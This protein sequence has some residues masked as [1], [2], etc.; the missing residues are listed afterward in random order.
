[1]CCTLTVKLH[2]LKWYYIEIC[3]FISPEVIFLLDVYLPQETLC[4]YQ[5]IK[6]QKNINMEFAKPVYSTIVLSSRAVIVTGSEGR[7]HSFIV[8]SHKYLLWPI[9]TLTSK[10]WNYYTQQHLL[11][12]NTAKPRLPITEFQRPFSSNRLHFANG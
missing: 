2:N 12:W 6:L 1:M 5:L 7:M 10:K 4:N 8:G 9:T 11:C 3:S